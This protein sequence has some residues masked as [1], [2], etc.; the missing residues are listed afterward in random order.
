MDRMLLLSVINFEGGRTSG[1]SYMGPFLIQRYHPQTAM[2][3]DLDS[4]SASIGM[5]VD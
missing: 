3:N 1:K 4:R 2:S 5:A